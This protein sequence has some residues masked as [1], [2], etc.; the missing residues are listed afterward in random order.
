MVFHHQKKKTRR[1]D[2]K[3][4]QYGINNGHQYGALIKETSKL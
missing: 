3:I 2:F 4:Q 1:I